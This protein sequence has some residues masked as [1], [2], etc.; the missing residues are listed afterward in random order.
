MG[1]PNTPTEQIIG[2][3]ARIGQNHITYEEQVALMDARKD[4]L[5]SSLKYLPLTILLDQRIRVEG[6]DLIVPFT[7]RDRQIVL[8]ERAGLSYADLNMR[9]LFYQSLFTTL[10]SNLFG[11]DQNGTW[12]SISFEEG[13]ERILLVDIQRPPTAEFVQMLGSRACGSF[14]QYLSNMVGD[15]VQDRRKK[16]E[17]AEKLERQMVIDDAL[18][19]LF[20][21]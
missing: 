15:W 11:L 21:F 9:G 4:V 17:Q 6:G 3:K 7:L 14:L 5:R 18:I 13:P 10:S 16:L 1:T 20:Y 19:H 2:E 8:V 12:V